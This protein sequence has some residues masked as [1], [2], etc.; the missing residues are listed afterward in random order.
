VAAF[1][2]LWNGQDK[3]PKWACLSL[4]FA[5]L[6]IELLIEKEVALGEPMGPSKEVQ[7]VMENLSHTQIG[8]GPRLL[9]EKWLEWSRLPID[10]ASLPQ[11][12]TPRLDRK[13][14][15]I[16]TV[17]ETAILSSTTEISRE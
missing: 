2:E 12:G 15:S 6:C 4:H 5:S 17:T 7:N 9:I 11:V 8:V 13:L 1:S 14:P 3:W 16:R 10:H